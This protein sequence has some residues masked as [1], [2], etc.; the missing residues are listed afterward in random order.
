VNAGTTAIPGRPIELIALRHRSEPA[1]TF[2]VSGRVRNPADSR[3]QRQV[4][5]VV[6]LI[7]AN[8]RILTSQTTPLEQPLLEAGQTSAFSVVFPRVTGTVARYQVRFR[9]RGGDTIPHVDRRTA[10][11]P[12]KAPAS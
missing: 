6:N 4:E 11:A 9:A 10:E 5:A 2:D 8:G 7:D 12:A 1:T 3:A